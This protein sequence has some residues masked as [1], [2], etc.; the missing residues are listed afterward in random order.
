MKTL[1]GCQ[2]PCTIYRAPQVEYTNKIFVFFYLIIKYIIMSEQNIEVAVV[3]RQ[4][5]S[6][7]FSMLT[8][9]KF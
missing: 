4:V 2:G 5:M 8:K 1:T 9:L 7:H 3:L 6:G